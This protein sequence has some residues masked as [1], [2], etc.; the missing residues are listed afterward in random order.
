VRKSSNY[1]V[2][3]LNAFNGQIIAGTSTGVLLSTDNGETWN[4][5]HSEGAIHAVAFIDNVIYAMYLSGAIFMSTDSGANWTKFNYAPNYWSYIYDLAKIGDHLLM[6]NNYGLF[7][8]TD[9]GKSWDNFYK[10]ERFVFFDF[11]A[12]DTVVYGATRIANEF[13]N[14]K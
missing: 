4:H 11:L 7:N 14:R 9:S 8:S 6:S 3:S 12:A 2:L 10:E 5:I 13:R 1:Q